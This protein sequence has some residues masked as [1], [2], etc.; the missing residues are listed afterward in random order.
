MST[1][2]EKGHANPSTVGQFLLGAAV[3]LV[4][5]LI[6][7]KE[8]RSARRLLQSMPDGVLSDMGISRGSIDHATAFG[9]GA[10]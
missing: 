5:L 4:R 8:M 9:R 1:L 3:G 6:L 7:W 10:I 2:V